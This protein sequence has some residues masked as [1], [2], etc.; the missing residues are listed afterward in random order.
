MSSISFR[1]RL[2]ITPVPATNHVTMELV[3]NVQRRIQNIKLEVEEFHPLLKE[4][5]SRHPEII[6]FEYTHGT[7]EMGADFILIRRD[8]F[9][10]R[11]DYVGVIAKRGKIHQ[12]LTDVYRQIEECLTIRRHIE[13]GKK[14]VTLSAVMI[15]ATD[16][17][18]YGAQKKI[19]EAYRGSKIQFLSG[20]DLASLIVDHV[21]DYLDNIPLPISSYLHR[22]REDV[23][24]QDAS[25]DI[26]TID[27]QPIYLPQRV[28]RLRI[29]PYTEH[30]SVIQHRDQVN[31]ATEIQARRAILLEADM[32]G[33]KS[34]LLRHLVQS[35]AHAN[36]FGQDPLLPVPTTYRAL[37]DDYNGSL[38]RL[39]NALVPEEVRTKLPKNGQ[40]V[41]FVDAIDEKDLPQCE[42]F[43]SL[44]SLLEEA[45]E[46]RRYR[47]VLTSRPIRNLDFD[48]EFA[49]RLARYEI[50]RLSMGQI[51]TYLNTI[52]DR[53]NLTKRIIDDI[54][55]SPLFHDIPKSPLAAVLLGQVLRDDP[56]DL[57]STLPELYSKYLEL[58]LG[59]WDIRK[60][61]QTEKEYEALRAILME[62]AR[63]VLENQLNYVATSELRDMIAT[64]LDQRNLTVTVE[65]V[66]D[67]AIR[68]SD[69]LVL[70]RDGLRVRFKHRTFAEFLEASR[71]IRLGVMEPSLQA[72]EMY[73]SNVYYFACGEAKDAPDL[74][75]GLAKVTP[76]EEQHRWLKAMNMANFI[77]A[78][79]ATPYDVIESAVYESILEASTLFVDIVNGTEESR[80]AGLSR[81]HLLCLIQLIIR[82]HY[83][84]EF[85]GGAL[86]SAAL[87]GME[88]APRDVQPYLLFLLAVAAVDAGNK[89]AFKTL[90]EEY[91]TALPIDVSLGIGHEREI[92]GRNKQLKRFEKRLKRKIRGNEKL[93]S[94]IKL[95]Y[96]R[97]IL[98]AVVAEQKRLG[99]GGA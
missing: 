51:I 81:M 84:F 95:L 60:G 17:I 34:K 96:D 82:D 58:A 94:D 85:F 99:T 57:P 62:L 77:M 2:S 33:G 87:E 32:G 89:D 86:E 44:K 13:G 74:I 70:S 52:C 75:G 72:F 67:N 56:K 40:I 45:R 93:K 25:L 14:E 11:D 90:V 63:Y 1:F 46:H 29:D 37:V 42:L 98:A 28:D 79:Y 23:L 9:L 8:A 27:G 26:L 30:A 73:W 91:A 48:K 20:N 35:L 92:S 5:F 16:T 68:R 3:T 54:R 18:T 78:A 19:N 64:Y 50:R 7:Q 31:I 41:I 22:V 12:D 71:R 55:R 66:Y 4:L 59:R 97:P 83:G 10:S 6:R 39:V 49:N 21:P 80:F 24:E 69:V 61:L 88:S 15:V 47:L 53:L 76:A 36:A 38:T 65:T 43:T